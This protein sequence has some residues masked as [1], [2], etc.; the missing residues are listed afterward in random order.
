MTTTN[1]KLSIK[2]MDGTHLK[3]TDE[4]GLTTDN[5]MHY[6][7]LVQKNY[8]NYNATEIKLFKIGEGDELN[9]FKGEV[10]LFCLN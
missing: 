2:F 6:K 8:M 1:N 3:F 10:E 7:K 5:I 4:D 9:H